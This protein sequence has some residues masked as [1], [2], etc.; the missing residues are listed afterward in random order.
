MGVPVADFTDRFSV[1]FIMLE[2]VLKIDLFKICHFCD[3]QFHIKLNS[4]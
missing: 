1:L 3:K 2:S 4:L